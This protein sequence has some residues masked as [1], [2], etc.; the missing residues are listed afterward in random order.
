MNLKYMRA[1]K[2]AERI[3][4]ENGAKFHYQDMG[5]GYVTW[6]S[7][8][9]TWDEEPPFIYMAVFPRSEEDEFD[10]ESGGIMDLSMFRKFLMST[11]GLTVR[12]A[13][14]QQVHYQ[15][16]WWTIMSIVNLNPD[17]QL[18]IFYRG[19]LQRV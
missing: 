5:Q 2:S 16:E 13:P 1:R 15:G 4:R 7:E 6:D 19:V 10:S 11:E 18:D 12:P 14:Q 3:I 9:V 8:L 17:G